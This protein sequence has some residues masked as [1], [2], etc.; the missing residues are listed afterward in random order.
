MNRA[1]SASGGAGGDGGG[2]ASED[3]LDEADQSLA[4]EAGPSR[5]GEAGGV[6]QLTAWAME[7]AH[8]GHGLGPS[9]RQKRRWGKLTR[10]HAGRALARRPKHAEAV[11]PRAPVCQSAEA[12]PREPAQES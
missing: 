3:E 9:R 7:S 10:L 8:A 1:G 4:G 5:V 11:A 12:T 6:D 2:E